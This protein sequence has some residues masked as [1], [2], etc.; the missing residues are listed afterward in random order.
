MK[1]WFA[2]L[3]TA[4]LALPVLAAGPEA[5]AQADRSLWP[6]AM[7]SSSSFDKASRAEILVF[8]G[9]L[10]EVAAQDDAALKEQLKIKQVDRG[11]VQKVQKRL[12]TQLLANWK[13][14]TTTCTS[15]E[16][17]CP[18]VNSADSLLAASHALTA[19]L[20]GQYRP[21]YD[22]ALAFH[23]RYAGELVRLA[24]LFPRISSE[25]DTFSSVEK[26]GSELPDRH[27]LLTFD[28]GPTNKN[29]STDDLLPILDKAG[30]HA[31]FYMLGERLE[32]RL[33]QDS[34]ASLQQGYA[35]QC[36]AMHGWQHQSHAKWSEW[37]SSVLKTRDLAKQTFPKQYRPW[38]R[39]PYGQRQSD[40][41]AFFSSNGLGVALWN[42][43]SQ[44]WNN[45]VKASNAGQ[46][47]FTLMLLWRHGVI[48]F[49]DIHPKAI[50]AVPWL[51]ANTAKTGVVWD[52]CRSY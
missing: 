41:G 48:L 19:Q 40:S 17:F 35:K 1:Q 29:G 31:T 12:L 46:R 8:A 15:T 7:T 5:V 20:P 11:S 45:H 9:A 51:L 21:W 44:D 28:D 13:Q 30:L 50:D 34:A 37:Q 32:A 6:E 22:N 18:A 14:A 27:F 47:V 36:V 2:G 23:K 4:V 38:F 3:S 52:D 10:A 49:H 25:I 43:D 24:A 16:L 33:K 39:P 26:D 42:I